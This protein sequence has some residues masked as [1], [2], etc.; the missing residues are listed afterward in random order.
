M[1]LY[2]EVCPFGMM[3]LK[4]LGEGTGIIKG[5]RRIADMN[6]PLAAGHT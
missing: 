2:M 3:I 4:Q 6:S 5:V 1:V